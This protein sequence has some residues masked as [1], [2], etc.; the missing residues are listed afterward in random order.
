MI[1]RWSLPVWRGS[2]TTLRLWGGKRKEN[3]IKIYHKLSRWIRL[4]TGSDRTDSCRSRSICLPKSQVCVPPHRSSYTRNPD[5]STMCNNW[6]F[7]IWIQSGIE[8]NL[9]AR[10]PFKIIFCWSSQ[11]HLSQ[12]YEILPKM[13]IFCAEYST[14]YR[15]WWK[16]GSK[17]RLSYFNHQLRSSH[18][19]L[20]RKVFLGTVVSGSANVLVH[21]T[22]NRQNCLR[23]P[24][25]VLW[26]LE[27]VFQNFKASLYLIIDS[28]ENEGQ[29]ATV[30]D[31][32][33]MPWNRPSPVQHRN[34]LGHWRRKKLK[35]P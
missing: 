24:W 5:R 4:R 3:I 16:D 22:R 18:G 33:V 6:Q 20:I 15:F 2:S 7:P 29:I 12:K 26:G 35:I 31:S 21:A 8:K 32:W 9:A 28:P 27:Q 13:T 34:G 19:R 10:L 11:I 25:T 17:I 23:L 30:W 14:K 1:T